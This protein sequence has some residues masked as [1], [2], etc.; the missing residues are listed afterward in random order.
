MKRS[1]LATW[2]LKHLGVD[3]AVVGDLMER[4]ES[5][6]SR[7]WLWRQVLMASLHVARTDGLLMIGAVVFGWAVLWLFFRF[8]GVPLA[9]FDGYLLANGMIE[10]YSAGWW[11][12]SALMWIVMGA[13]FF[14]SGWMVAKVASR[15]PRLPVMTFALSVSTAILIALILDTGQGDPA[16]LHMWLTV[17]LFVMVAPAT[18]I[19]LGGF[20]AARR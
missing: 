6:R 3:D 5:G 16:P 13:P 20:T 18:A 4:H 11:V 14:A 17:P 9:R 2:C 10:R 1:G 15:T 7:V 19:A 12:R 8:V